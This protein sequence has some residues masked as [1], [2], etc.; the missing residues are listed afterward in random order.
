MTTPRLAGGQRLLVEQCPSLSAW[1][2]A[3][4]A[5]AAQ[6]AL[7]AADQALAG[8]AVSDVALGEMGAHTV[9]VL[10]RAVDSEGTVL[11]ALHLDAEAG[12]YRWRIPTDTELAAMVHATLGELVPLAGA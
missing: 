9:A 8:A 10:G 1:T 5:L 6:A 12:L 3:Q 7:D 11:V 2:T 4:C